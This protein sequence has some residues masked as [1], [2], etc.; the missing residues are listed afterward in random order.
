MAAGFSRISAEDA[1]RA[2]MG[3]RAAKWPVRGSGRLEPV[4]A[5]V[6]T[7]GFRLEEGA[8]V[9]TIGS[10][11]ARNIEISLRD[12]GLRIPTLDL[13]VPAAELMRGSALRTG[14]LN[15]YTPFSMLNEIEQIGAEDDGGRFLIDLGNDAWW[16]GQLHS[17]EP[18]THERGLKRRRRIRRLYAE[19]IAESALVIVTLGL[20]E[21]W[22]DE[23]EQVY[24]NDTVPRQ[25]IDRHPGRFFFEVLSPEKVTDAVMRLVASLHALNPVQRMLLTVSPVPL[26]RSFTGGDVLSANA[27]SKSALRVAAEIATRS[28]DH[29]DYF[30]SFESV[31]LSDRAIA[32]EDD[33]AHVTPA[34]I[35]LN[36]SRMIATYMPTATETAA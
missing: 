10:C 11:F 33:L 34:M 6:V 32:W 3:Q 25:V 7:P 13:Q 27:Y 14:I 1:Y 29:V 19:S 21:A 31:T 2:T 22:W 35:E 26:H 5:P 9:F 12:H 15:K 23:A 18:V 8:S 17:H 4:A 24:L 28:F 20:V 30:P 36:V 16:D